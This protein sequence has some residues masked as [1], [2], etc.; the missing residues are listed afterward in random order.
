[1]ADRQP[2]SWTGEPATGPSHP[3]AL[4]ICTT[5][6]HHMLCH[7]LMP[8]SGAEVVTNVTEVVIHVTVAMTGLT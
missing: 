6:V 5:P 3:M 7:S 8:S 2:L 1:M 4:N